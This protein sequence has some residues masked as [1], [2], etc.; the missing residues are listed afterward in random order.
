V[1][2]FNVFETTNGSD[3]WDPCE[4][5]DS[6]IELRAKLNDVC[7]PCL[8]VALGGHSKNKDSSKAICGHRCAA[9][10]CFVTLAKGGICCIMCTACCGRTSCMPLVFSLLFHFPCIAGDYLEDNFAGGKRKVDAEA[11]AGLRG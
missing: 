10:E 1:K 6:C 4:V 5:D 9:S 7:R 2:Q 3:G 11:L 8:S